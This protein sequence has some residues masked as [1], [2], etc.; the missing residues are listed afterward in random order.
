M[1]MFSALVQCGCVLMGVQWLAGCGATSGDGAPDLD[2]DGVEV[3]DVADT[4]A[5]LT[6]RD[7]YEN[8][9]GDILAAPVAGGAQVAKVACNFSYPRNPKSFM[10]G[11]QTYNGEIQKEIEFSGPGA[12]GITFNCKGHRINHQSSEGRAIAVRTDQSG[13]VPHHITIKDCEV[14]GNIRLVQGD[15]AICSGCAD[16]EAD[17]I[18]RRQATAPHHIYMRNLKITVAKTG[19]G[20][21]FSGGVTFSSLSNSSIRGT[22]D[23]NTAIYLSPESANNAIVGNFIGVNTENRE[24]IAID[25]SANNYIADNDLSGLNHG[26]IYIFRNCG[27]SGTVRIQKPWHNSI[28]NNRFYY[29]KFD[30]PDDYPALWVAS[31][32]F[33]YEEDGQV[34][35]AN[36]SDYCDLD[37]QYPFGSGID[38]ADNAKYTVAAHNQIR[39]GQHGL[40][41]AETFRGPTYADAKSLPFDRFG[42]TSVTDLSTVPTLAIGAA[43]EPPVKESLYVVQGTRLWR[44]DAERGISVA[45]KA[46]TWTG[47]TSMATLGSKLY[48]IQDG[49][50][51]E[52]DPAS[53]AHRH[54]P[55]DTWAGPTSMA[56]LGERLFVVQDGALWVVDDFSTGRASA[57]SGAGTWAGATSMA[58]VGGYLYIVQDSTLWR[59]N[60]NTGAFTPLGGAAWA[61]PTL[62]AVQT[63]P[64]ALLIIQ[65]GSLWRVDDLSTGSFTQLGPSGAWTDATSM[66]YMNGKLY[67]IQDNMLW[68]VD[69]STG[70]YTPIE[71]PHFDYSGPTVMAAFVPRSS[72]KP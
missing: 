7:C 32:T 23:R 27:Q 25:G 45:L 5:A 66:T 39:K 11:N 6:G 68:S 9:I 41:V 22:L 36:S 4:K 24:Q 67:V 37:R 42:N 3:G 33:A 52:V 71:R 19:N 26:G 40:S 28:V 69:P 63:S 72:S 57:L 2:S 59:V 13:N 43:G 1:K 56:A 38:D 60:S 44:T 62:M 64:R 48:I 54:L 21:H 8:E 29:E 14:N 16:P 50:L 35:Y 58:A 20:V 18:A 49:G 65:D 34:Y 46:T 15:Q 12:V 55:A 53:G 47:S 10:R 31:R 17:A 70:G 51:Y 61:G 30:D